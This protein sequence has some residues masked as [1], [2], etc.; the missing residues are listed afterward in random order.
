MN[1]SQDYN[2]QE[3][4]EITSVSEQEVSFDDLQ[5]IFNEQSQ[6]LEKILDSPQA[7]PHRLD[8]SVSVS[9][10]RRLQR[11][12]FFL[13]LVLFFFAATVMFGTILGQ[14]NS[15]IYCRILYMALDVVFVILSVKS[16]YVAFVDYRLETVVKKVKRRYVFS[17]LIRTVALGLAS[18]FT[19]V[20]VSCTTTVG[21]GFVMTQPQSHNDRTEI[22]DIIYDTM[23]KIN[24]S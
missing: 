20:M 8:L 1:N 5:A 24:N 6:R 2:L 14:Q 7:Q 10:R 9:H 11:A 13:A 23:S 19:I 3:E 18:V 4:R 12:W 21:D 15:D 16:L 22:V 17:S